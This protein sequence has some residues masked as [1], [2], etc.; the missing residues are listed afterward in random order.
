MYILYSSELGLEDAKVDGAALGN[1][2][3]VSAAPK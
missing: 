3:G 1:L 2:D